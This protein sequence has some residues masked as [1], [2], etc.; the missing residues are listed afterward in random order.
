MSNYAAK[1]KEM[2]TQG[3]ASDE[4]LECE[5]Y[6]LDNTV[7]I[8]ETHPKIKR[9]TDINKSKS[10]FRSKDKKHITHSKYIIYKDGSFL[11]LNRNDITS[12]WKY[13]ALHLRKDFHET[14]SIMGNSGKQIEFDKLCARD[15]GGTISG[16]REGYRGSFAPDSIRMVEKNETRIAQTG[17]CINPWYSGERG[18]NGEKGKKGIL[19]GKYFTIGS[20]YCILKVLGCKVGKKNAFNKHF[21]RITKRDRNNPS[22]YIDWLCTHTQNK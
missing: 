17:T 5:A 16:K 19:T 4:L 20:I 15:G 2:S 22:E 21:H 14:I 18:R 3:D 11:E 7:A 1:I 10:A 12:K 6:E 13:L 9:L 8:K